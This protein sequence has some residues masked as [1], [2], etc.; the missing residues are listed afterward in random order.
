[1]QNFSIYNDS[2]SESCQDNFF[3]EVHTRAMLLVQPFK[4]R[5]GRFFDPTFE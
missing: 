4:P 3:R 1:M 5:M 2:S